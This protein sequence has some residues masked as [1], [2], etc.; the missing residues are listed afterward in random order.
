MHLPPM[1]APRVAAAAG[2]SPAT[3]VKPSCRSHRRP[4]SRDG[5]TAARL[6][7]TTHTTPGDGR[8][9]AVGL[10]PPEGRPPPP[11]RWPLQRG[12][13]PTSSFR[14]PAVRGASDGVWQPPPLPPQPQT[15][16]SVPPPLAWSW[17]PTR[18]AVRGQPARP[19]CVTHLDGL[20]QSACRNA[21]CHAGRAG[22]GWPMGNG[23]CESR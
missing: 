1:E 19:C 3:A 15:R 14:S 20:R 10:R 12:A 5:A 16:R 2:D 6:P 4:G 18:F 11:A 23:A 8:S 13:P 7:P 22:E 17:G 21:A 9:A